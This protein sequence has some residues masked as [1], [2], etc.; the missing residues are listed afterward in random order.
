M[1]VTI[2]SAHTNLSRGP[3]QQ[4]SGGSAT[5]P[6]IPCV[7][8][9]SMNDLTREVNPSTGREEER[10]STSSYSTRYTT[11]EPMRNSRNKKLST[12]STLTYVK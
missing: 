12:G 1:E 2:N 9:R 8:T 10:K 11:P 3:G 7:M 6:M 5:V 4:N